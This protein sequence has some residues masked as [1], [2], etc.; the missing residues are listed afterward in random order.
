MHAREASP[1]LGPLVFGLKAAKVLEL[2]GGD[3]PSMRGD[4]FGVQSIAQFDEHFHV[5]C[6]V[7]QLSGAQWAAST[8]PL[9]RGPSP[10]HSRARRP[11]GQ[12]G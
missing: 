7:R 6:G 3:V 8:S 11:P 9:P 1:R 5:E 2:L 12:P 4:Q 10:V